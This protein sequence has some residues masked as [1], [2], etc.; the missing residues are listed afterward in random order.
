MKKLLLLLLTACLTYSCTREPAPEQGTA[1]PE[2]S[3]VDIALHFGPKTPGLSV[4]ATKTTQGVAAENRV[5]NIYVF[6]FDGDGN[7]IYGRYFDHTNLSS[8]GASTLADWWEVTNNAEEDGELVTKGTIHLHT[9]SRPGCRVAAI[10]NIDAEM[11]NISPEQ[12]S[13]VGT[14]SDLYSQK[15]TLNQLITSRSGYFPMSG[16]L[17]NVDTGID[18]SW[19]ELPLRRLDAKIEFRVYVDPST[20][21]ET[22]EAVSKVA[23]FEPLNWQVINIP[24]T[25]YV[26]EH[27][28]F[29]AGNLNLNADQRAA[30]EDASGATPDDYFDLGETNFETE[31][32]TDYFYSGTNQYRKFIHGFSFYML[33]NRKPL[34]SPMPSPSEYRMRELQEKNA[35]IVPGRVSNGDFVYPDKY[36]TYVIISAR[37]RMN[38]A[39]FGDT[40]DATL[41]GDVRY[42]IHLGDFSNDKWEDFNVFRNHRYVYDIIVH[43]VND[44]RVEVEDESSLENEPGASGQ[45][46]VALEDIFTSDAHY[47]SHVVTFH[48]KNINPE[49]VSWR[50][51][52]PFNPSGA[53]PVITNGYE[54]NAGL[55]FRWVTF[56]V[57]AKNQDNIYYEDRRQVYQP[58]DETLSDDDK[59]KTRYVSGL[60]DYLKKQKTLF[61]QDPALS[62]FD[63]TPDSEGGPKISVTAFVDEYYYERN[64]ITG[65]VQPDLWKSFVN[66]PMRYMYILSDTQTSADGESQIIGSSFTIRQKSIQSIYNINNPGLL[67]AWGCEHSDD[68]MENNIHYYDKSGSGDRGNKSHSNGRI[69]TLMEWEMLNPNGTVKYLGD[70]TEEKAY[71]RNYLNLE[72]DNE[73]PLMLPEYQYLRY[74]CLSRNRDNNGNGVI[75]LDEVRW[76]MGSHYQLIGLFMGSYGI[77]GDARLYQRNAYERAQTDKYIWRQHV[78]AS[79]QYDTNSSSNPYVI[80]GEECLS[81]GN[82]SDSRN[83]GN[84]LDRFST[85][86]VRNLGYDPATGN[87][88]TYSAPTVEPED[89]VIVHRL[90][91]GEPYTGNFDENVYYEFDCSR[92][93]E[94]SLRYYTNRELSPHDEFS[95]QACLYPYFTFHAKNEAVDMGKLP[96]PLNGNNRIH[97][98]N[99]YLNSNIADNPYCPPGY[100]IPNVRELSVLHDFIPGGDITSYLGGTGI[101]APGRTHWSFGTAGEFY[102]PNRGTQDRYGWGV[103]YQKVFMLQESQNAPAV[104]CV[105]DLKPEEMTVKD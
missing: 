55:D 8:S 66:Q 15:A 104:R 93:N 6:I 47:S 30:I 38:N 78:I 40:T 81:A 97:L 41:S 63:S 69:N 19:G 64:P 86:C 92:I 62:D 67:S 100:R 27:G 13:T 2:G 80:W 39:D 36:S 68:E 58:V 91:F 94:A 90:R 50:V 22:G 45:V 75:D 89:Y 35:T 95:E 70:E 52:T 83:Y 12:L 26:L 102:N 87:D 14:Y 76:Y 56:R 3:P 25:A 29:H 16:E 49:K 20:D 96:S 21:P 85:R 44:I 61:D 7:K 43:D 9:I 84:G 77:E 11:V 98:L 46:T 79:T 10:A 31:E 72:A 99:Q 17:E 60:V 101:N 24:K 5:Y 88:I 42:V 37:V 73:T 18:A 71:W 4:T 74:S 28:A 1:V 105:K 57:N 54:N 103:S 34:R 23:E 33:E 32:V 59:N 82:P 65:E 53:G 51:K 48:A